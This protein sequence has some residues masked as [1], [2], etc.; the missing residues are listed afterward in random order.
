[1]TWGD[2]F[3]AKDL[4]QNYPSMDRTEQ[5]IMQDPNSKWF[6][7]T[8]T[9]TKETC[10]DIINK[11]FKASVN[12][13]SHHYGKPGKTWQWGSV[14]KLEIL[15]LTRQEAFSSGNFPT[16]GTGSTIN[17]LNNGHG[18]SWRMVVQMGPTVKGYGI[19]PG[20]ESG[21]P[22]SFFYDDMLKTWQQGKL[23][24]LLFLQ[25]AD[26]MPDRI[27]STLNIGSK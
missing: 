21:N 13:L 22:G 1:M 27:K 7:D 19:L 16:G 2:D 23:K 3:A 20:G 24:E 25:S 6:D 9:P 18:P 14:K 4:Q 15:H 5:L 12:E 8:R 11:A 17:A 26:E 10:A